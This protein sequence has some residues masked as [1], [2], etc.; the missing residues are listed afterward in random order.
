MIFS[1]L[2]YGFLVYLLY[3]LVF[4]FI[5]PVYRT[6]KQVKKG[7]REMQEKMYQQNNQP[8]SDNSST[9]TKTKSTGDKQ[10]GDYIDFEEIK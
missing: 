7:F 10:M 9:T 8:F 5:I 3:R 2:F 1:L 4:H 6:T